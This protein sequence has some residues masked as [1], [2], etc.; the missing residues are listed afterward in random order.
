MSASESAPPRPLLS[1][2]GLAKRFA[3]RRGALAGGSRFLPAL[4][5]IDFDLQGG[6]T[7][8]LVGE[9]GS[10]KTTA[11]QIV[12]RLIEPDAGSIEFAGEDWLALSGRALRRRR[13]DLQVVFQDPL[14]SLNP[15]MRAGEQIAEPL[16]VQR[17]ATKAAR[18]ERV[19]SLL[20]DVGLAPEIASR[21]PSELSGGQ[22]QRVAIAR[23]LAT[24]PEAPRLRRAGL[25][26]GRLGRGADHQ[27]AAGPEGAH[28]PRLPLHRARSRGRLARRGFDR[29]PLPGLDRRDRSQRGRSAPAS[30]SL[31]GGAA[32]RGAGDGRVGAGASADST[33]RGSALG[34]GSAFGL[35]LS[36]PLPDRPAA[37][38]GGDSGLDGI[39]RRAFGGLLL[40]RRNA[41]I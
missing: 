27:P 3:I 21:F 4:R 31:H 33:G 39:R 11:G 38:P 7:L 20:E 19:R 24:Q 6:E 32:G 2:R 22:R 8:G 9:S 12:A 15:R 41:V 40:S 23:A 29:G 16:R 13:R 28:G 35:R 36:S 18:R 10:G 26:A 1:A 37:L 30:S 17:L 14:T 34:L 25:G 5:G